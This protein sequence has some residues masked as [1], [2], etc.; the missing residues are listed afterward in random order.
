MSSSDYDLWLLPPEP[1]PVSGTYSI[2]LEGFG[3]EVE[4][5]CDAVELFVVFEVSNETDALEALREQELVGD[6]VPKSDGEWLALGEK[7]LSD[8]SEGDILDAVFSQNEIKT[9]YF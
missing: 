1:E 4:V 2:V 7:L 5:G 3:C 8:K 6:E 9:R